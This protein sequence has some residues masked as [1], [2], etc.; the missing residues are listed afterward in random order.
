M[1]KKKMTKKRFLLL[2]AWM[3]M[4]RRLE[5]RKCLPEIRIVNLDLRNAVNVEIQAGRRKSPNE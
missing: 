5:K 4:R 1:A 2:R 3:R